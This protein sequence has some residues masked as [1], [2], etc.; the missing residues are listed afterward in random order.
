MLKTCAGQLLGLLQLIFNMSL[1]LERVPEFWKTSCLVPVPKKG[2]SRALN[3]YGPVVL[4]CHIMM[5]LGQLLLGVLRLLVRPSLD[6][7]QVAYEEQFGVDD[8][9]L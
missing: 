7:L 2:N 5:T 4:A 3:D 9:Y 1:K 8:T 6:P